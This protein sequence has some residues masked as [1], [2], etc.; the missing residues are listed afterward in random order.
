MSTRTGRA[1]NTKQYKANKMELM[2]HLTGLHIPQHHYTQADINFYFPFPTST[3]KKN[4]L[5]NTPKTT[6][7]DIDNLAKGILD[8]LEQ[9]KIIKNDS[10]IHS[11]TLCK[12]YT[13]H[14]DGYY[15]LTLKYDE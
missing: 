3:A 2:F 6:K 9:T 1:Y 5:H 14:N 12:R 10:Q 8:A 4:R 7:P 11:L 13:V 15:F